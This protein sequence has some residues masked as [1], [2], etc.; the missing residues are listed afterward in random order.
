MRYP[1]ITFGIT[2][3]AAIAAFSARETFKIHLNDCG[4]KWAEPVSDE[5]YAKARLEAANA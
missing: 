4:E 3:L 5:E 2:I 1:R